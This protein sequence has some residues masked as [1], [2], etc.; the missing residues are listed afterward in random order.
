MTKT[1]NTLIAAALATS[2]GTAALTVPAS[3]GGSLSITVLPGNAKD[4]QAM[5]LGLGLY[6]IAQGIK[7]GS[8][9]QKGNGNA[10][11]LAQNGK[12]NLGIVHQDGNGHNG[13]LQQNG[14]GNAYGLFQ[15]GKNTNGH[16]AQNGHGNTGAT[17]QFG[18]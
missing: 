18:W 7:G 1:L 11:G 12:G 17:F 10:A 3:A 16:V 8:I 13:S 4:Q 6:A 5:R 2:L 9:R 14:H 15:F